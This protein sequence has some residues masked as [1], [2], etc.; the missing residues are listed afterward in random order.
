M[1]Q[2]EELSTRMAGWYD[3]LYQRS[4]NAGINKL[5]GAM[6]DLYN[7]E[8]ETEQPFTQLVREF[9]AYRQDCLASNREIAAFMLAY[10]EMAENKK[11]EIAK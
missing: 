2:Y 8:T 1:E 3:Y 10:A 4:G 6:V 11:K 9:I 5:I 7:G